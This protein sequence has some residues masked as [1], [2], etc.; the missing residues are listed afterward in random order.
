MKCRWVQIHFFNLPEMRH[1]SSNASQQE[2]AY[3]E[4][5]KDLPNHKEKLL[6]DVREPNELIETGKIPTSINM[7][8]EFVKGF[9]H[10]T[11][12]YHQHHQ[13]I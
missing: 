13:L 9:P 11:I 8:R 7:P 6:I 4:E 3:Y 1:F 5:I 10:L 12:H 2:I